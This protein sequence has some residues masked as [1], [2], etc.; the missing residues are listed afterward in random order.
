MAAD[1]DEQFAGAPPDQH[2]EQ[3]RGGD[4]HCCLNQI[5][6]SPG[7]IHVGQSDQST[8]HQSAEVPLPADPRA[9]TTK[10]MAS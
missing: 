10:V 9:G 3:R 4:R 5:P 2:R 7:R 1:A 6:P 8:G